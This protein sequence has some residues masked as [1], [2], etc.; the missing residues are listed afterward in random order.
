METRCDYANISELWTD[1]NM[2][3]EKFTVGMRKETEIL[4]R[5]Y[6][7]TIRAIAYQ[8]LK[9]EDLAEDCLQEVMLRLSTVLDRIGAYGSPEAKG[10]INAIARNTAIDMRRAHQ[11][12][13][14]NPQNEEPDAEI[15]KQSV[16][17]FSI[18]YPLA[19]GFPE[20]GQHRHT[21]STSWTRWTDKVSSQSAITGRH[22]NLNKEI[23]EKVLSSQQDQYRAARQPRTQTSGEGFDHSRRKG[24]RR[25]L[26]AR[27]PF[28]DAA[29][30]LSRT[31]FAGNRASMLR[32]SRPR[33]G[34][35]QLHA[36]TYEASCQRN[37]RT[38]NVVPLSLR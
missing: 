33:F 32:A 11:R 9:D 10:Y 8:Y 30:V 23:G 37:K 7:K 34:A 25:R 3:F 35:S 38:N 16:A 28:A 27:D 4:Y 20:E 12:A 13:M 1:E 15:A 19:I 29:D 5:M 36:H 17:G 21:I 6:G 24:E 26:N 22:M 31:P 14:G 2:I 18:L